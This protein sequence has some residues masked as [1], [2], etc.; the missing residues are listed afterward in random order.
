MSCHPSD[1]VLAT[2][3]SLDGNQMIVRRAYRRRP[4]LFYL[5]MSLFPSNFL[6]A[7]SLFG[8]KGKTGVDARLR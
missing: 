6:S 3:A 4:I 1:V 7:T 2:L 5:R 8:E